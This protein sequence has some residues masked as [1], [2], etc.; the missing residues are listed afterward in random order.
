M[1]SEGTPDR[2]AFEHA[3]QQALLNLYHPA[4]LRQNPLA[5]L[6]A[7]DIPR[8]SPSS[9]GRLLVDAIGELKPP[10]SVP[11]SA[12]AWRMYHVLTYRYVEQSS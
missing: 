10:P 12:F 11:V 5:E 9:L 2:K 3:L 7:S 4:K 6:L 8:L 1:A